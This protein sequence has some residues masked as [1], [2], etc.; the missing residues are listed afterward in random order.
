MPIVISR[1]G[2][3]ADFLWANAMLALRLIM[4]HF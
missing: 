1:I 2:R 4:L 3:Q